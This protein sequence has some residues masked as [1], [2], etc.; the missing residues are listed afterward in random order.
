MAKNRY[1]MG[2]HNVISDISGFKFKRSECILVNEPGSLINGLMVHRSEYA[3]RNLQNNF[4]TRSYSPLQLPS[5][6]CF[7]IFIIL[8]FRLSTSPPAV[9]TE[10]KNMRA[11][12]IITALD[13]DEPLGLAA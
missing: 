7:R 10:A 1:R 8:S 4:H 6:D 5:R 13:T 12:L 2:D 3:P 11:I 9:R